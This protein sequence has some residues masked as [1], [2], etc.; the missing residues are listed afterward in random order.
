MEGRAAVL[1]QCVMRAM[2]D[3]YEDLGHVIG[4]TMKSAASHG[5]QTSREELIDVLKQLVEDGCAQAYMLSPEPPHATPVPLSDK[6]FEDLW[7][8][9]TPKGL[10]LVRRSVPL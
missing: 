10:S 1:K 7:F 2:A 5:L 4:W 9:L 3:D 6:D 8:Y